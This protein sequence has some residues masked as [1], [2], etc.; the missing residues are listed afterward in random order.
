M[1]T[2][3]EL[4]TTISKS[5]HRLGRANRLKVSPSRLTLRC[6]TC[7]GLPSNTFE[8]LVINHYGICFDCAYLEKLDEQAEYSKPEYHEYSETE[9]HND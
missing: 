7:G 3:K 1:L 9:L 4:I 2:Q 6:E 5:T 8:V